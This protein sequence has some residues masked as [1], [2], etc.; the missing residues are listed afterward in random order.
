MDKI[1]KAIGRFFKSIWD[2]I[3]T[4]AWVQPL[5]IVVIVF[6][7]IFSFSSSS[8]LMKWIKSLSNPDPTGEFFE[9]HD[10][11]FKQIYGDIYSSVPKYDTE[12]GKL[13]DG[14][15]AG[16]LLN[17]QGK[18]EGHTYVVFIQ[19]DSQESTFRAFYD[20]ILTKEEKDH[21]YVVDFRD[22]KN[23]KSEY[24]TVKKEWENDGGNVNYNYLL[25]TLYDFYI[26]EDFE[27]YNKAFTAKYNYDLKFTDEW[28]ITSD[29]ENAKSEIKFPVIC[30]YKG[31]ELI[32]FRFCDNFDSN[33]QNSSSTVLNDLHNGI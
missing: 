19:S 8:P 32:D 33:Y 11:D 1:F 21:F 20:N 22:E 5:L 15:D 25:N 31:T 2:W 4:T 30:K 7:I 6:T 14:K 27:E 28:E 26:S 12:E 16:K 13:P 29:I 23:L 24:N 3:K 9:K 17:N 18:Y 10:V